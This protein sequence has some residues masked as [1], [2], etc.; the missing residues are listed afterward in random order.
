VIERDD[1]D[2]DRFLSQQP[3]PRVSR[4]H[5]SPANKGLDLRPKY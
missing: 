2:I 5:G 4:G 1:V 3:P